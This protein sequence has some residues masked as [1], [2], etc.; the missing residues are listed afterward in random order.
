MSRLFESVKIGTLIVKNRLFMPA[1]NLRYCGPDNG[2]TERLIKFYERRAAGGVGLI[3]VG[4]VQVEN[5]GRGVMLSLGDDRYIPGFK[6]LTDRVHQSGAK[7]AAQLFHGGRYNSSK[8]YGRQAVAPSPIPS[9]MTGEPPRELTILEI[10]ELINKYGQAAGRAKE[11]G[12]DAVELLAGTGYLVSEFFSSLTNHRTDQYGGSFEN[13]VRFGVKI[14]QEIKKEVDVD[15]P[16]IV[17]VSGHEFMPGGNTNTEEAQFC[18][19]LEKAGADGFD[20]S[21]G[22]HESPIPQIT[23]HVPRG[24]FEYLARG[25]KQAVKVP[26]IACNRIPDPFTAK[27][28]IANGSA[29]MVGLSRVLI[30][31]PDWPRK[32]E[33]GAVDEIRP[34][35]GCNQGCLDE[36]FSGRSNRCLSNA[37]AGYE[38][39]R[40]IQPTANPKKVL[41][42]G[43][44]P[45][46][47][48]SA[49][50]LAKRGHHVELWEQSDILG[51]QL[52]LASR[53][54]GRN[55]WETLR[56]FLI[57]EVKRQGV[58]VK[59]GVTGT[60]EKITGSAPDVVIVA[61]GAKPNTP[62]IPG[63]TKAV[64][65]WD[66]LSGRVSTGNQVVVIGGGAV[67][68]ETAL[69]LAR[70]GAIS[71]EVLAFLVSYRSES[72]ENLERLV[73][74]GFKKV[75]LI[76]EAPKVGWSIGLS[77][78]WVTLSDL[79]RSN[80]SIKT[81]AKVIA[82]NDQGVVIEKDGRQETLIADTVVLAVGSQP[83]SEW[84]AQLRDYIPEVYTI[85]DAT[86]PRN[87]L[88]AIH[89]GYLVGYKI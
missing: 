4:G 24:A 15:Y 31:D 28:I 7:V 29:D 34:C 66:I 87:V 2:V 84:A 45:S 72:L 54:P 74:C 46:G 62:N 77:T 52:N 82:I 14:I 59:L 41:I 9:R 80:V 25:I 39:I 51:G 85:G 60:L 89:E 32:V 17:K 79:A 53:S 36:V 11:A 71:P 16:I 64:Q 49:R 33:T 78:R 8:A 47:L 18:A 42:I 83:N 48:E 12:F 67:G 86:Q 1:L 5:L 37:E 40:Q 56:R 44:G 75:F 50:V 65:A 68:C 57:N 76:D 21:G 3:M 30:A 22:W 10:E 55:E 38:E 81:K 43:G 58:V 88:E 61:T 6:E 63:A 13:R 35:I 69:Y 70:E 20:V 19:A 26:V 27:K 23:M 73:N